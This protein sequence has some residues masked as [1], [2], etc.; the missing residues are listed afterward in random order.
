MFLLLQKRARA[1]PL[2]GE[3]NLLLQQ[4][5]STPQQE[6]QSGG[7]SPYEQ[8][9]TYR[10]PTP[11]IHLQHQQQSVLPPQRVIQQPIE[12]QITHRQDQGGLVYQQQRQQLTHQI[13]VNRGLIPQQYQQQY[14]TPQIQ[15]QIV[16]QQPIYQPQSFAQRRIDNGDYNQFNNQQ[17]FQYNEQQA[18]NQLLNQQRL[19]QEQQLRERLSRNYNRFDLTPNNPAALFG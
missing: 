4:P 16:A 5:N 10:P 19:L 9:T 12:P 7:G 13:L 15:Q 8:P 1:I 17:V 2:P 6:Q 3:T 14:Y 18:Y 11:Y